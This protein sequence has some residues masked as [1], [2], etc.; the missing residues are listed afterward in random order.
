M[1]S[2]GLVLLS[3]PLALGAQTGSN[4]LAL[5]VEPPAK[6]GLREYEPNDAPSST[7]TGGSSGDEGP[8]PA[9]HSAAWYKARCDE[10]NGHCKFLADNRL[11]AARADRK[12]FQDDCEKQKAIL[13]EKKDAHAAEKT[14]VSHQVEDVAQAK[15][16]VKSATATV[17]DYAHCPPELEKW[18]AELSRLNAIPNKSPSDIDAEC[19]AQQK[20]LEAQQCVDKLRVAEKVL[21]D[22]KSQH[23][24]EKAH[25]NHEETHVG[26]AAQAVPPQG[27]VVIESCAKAED[28]AK[29][30]LEGSVAGILSNCKA[31]K[32]D[33]LD[34][35]GDDLHALDTECAKQKA[36]LSG[37]KD[38]HAEEKAEH[39]DQ[40]K[41]E[42][43]AKAKV[44]KAEVDV[45]ENAHCP[46]ELKDA[47][48]DLA[49]LEAIPNKATSDI[50]DECEA[51]QRVLKAEKCVDI[52]EAAKAVLAH[53]EGLHYKEQVLHADEAAERSHASGKI[54]PQEGVVAKVC[55]DFDAAKA[56]WESALASCKA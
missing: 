29:R 34:G 23:D 41:D 12:H 39:R 19:K 24:G 22:E 14:D 21:T 44:E 51:H 31:Q 47:K 16:E 43:A 1:K 53:K 10:I 40:A 15:L 35:L 13:K 55:A 38:D 54:P 33:L 50:D 26:P 8:G 32:D 37:H 42:A 6:S 49:R 30:P 4:F 27:E 25:L 7:S 3:T 56:L 18:K 11:N 20:V 52:Y 45:R 28:F 46:P 36:I 9:K 48:A 2:T 5:H 17:Q